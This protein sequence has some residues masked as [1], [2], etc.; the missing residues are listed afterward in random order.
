[1]RHLRALPL[2]ALALLSGVASAGEVRGVL[3]D[4]DGKPVVGAKLSGSLNEVKAVPPRFTRFTATTG[5]GGEFV[6]ANVPVMP[7]EKLPLLLIA[8][9]PSGGFSVVTVTENGAKAVLPDGFAKLSVKAVD[10]DGIPVPGATVEIGTIYRVPGNPSGTYFVASLG[11]EKDKIVKKTDAQGIAVFEGM[12][13]DGMASVKVKGDGRVSVQLWAQFP[14]AGELAQEATLT[15]AAVL[16][17]RVLLNGKPVPKVTVVATTLINHNQMA[18]RAVTDANGDYRITE[19]YPGRVSISVDLGKM[20]EDWTAKGYKLIPVAESAERSGLNIALEKGFLIHGKVLTVNGGKPVPKAGV[21]INLS[22]DSYLH[23]TT[24]AQGR[25]SAR[26]IPGEIYVSVS[27]LNREQFRGSVYARANVDA[28]HNSPIE[29]RVPDAALYPTIPNLVGTVVDAQGMPVAGA[30]VQNL[31][32]HTMATTDAGGNYRFEQPTQPGTLLVATKAGAMSKEVVTVLDQ[33]SITLKLDGETSTI[34]GAILDESGKPIPGVPVTLGGNQEKI[35]YNFPDTVTDDKGQYRFENVFGGLDYFFLWAKTPGYG[36]E[37]IQ[38]IRL[39]PGEKKTL[40]SIKMKVA[41]GTIDGQVL[42]T[43]GKPAVG[44][45]VS[46]QADGAENAMTDAQG[47]FHLKGVPRGEHYVV[48]YRGNMSAGATQAKTGQKNVVIK[49]TPAV[50]QKPT[51]VVYADRT[52]QEAPA[53]R[54]AGWV[55]DRPV[56]LK[57]LKGK[58]VVIDFWGLGCRP[59]L[60]SMPEIQA[61]YEKYRKEGVVMLGVCAPGAKRDEILKVIK[62]KGV[63]YPNAMDVPED[64]GVGVSARAF[65]ESGIPHLFVIDRNGKIVADT[66]EVIDAA[67][68]LKRLLGK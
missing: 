36:G 21:F 59:C 6:F 57:S 31:S 27:T 49:M 37:T 52:G 38:P 48:V 53:L 11:D 63:T 9:L 8:K 15:K 65:G 10:G 12:P 35:Y 44:V 46:S 62:E 41:D 54:T 3:V 42:E 51:G 55:N 50:D 28:K 13:V 32:T 25:F 19:A 1:M 5:P 40:D 24:D 33:E 17:G 7:T 43:D 16:S 29:L 30:V 4:K 56:D 58:I 22:N 61:L 26:V 2:L 20:E 64:S 66:H 34:S 23:R 68:A 67:R 14:K 39:A 47:R 18:A 45:Q 60:E